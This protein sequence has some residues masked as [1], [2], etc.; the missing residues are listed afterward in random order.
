[1][2]YEW[3]IAR[4]PLQD[5]QKYFLRRYYPYQVKGSRYRRISADRPSRR[6][7]SAPLIFRAASRV[8][9]SLLDRA[10]IILR[11]LRFVKGVLKIF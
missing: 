9:T 6:S 8:F 7:G 11:I 1:M 2:E 5:I 4:S 10:P 3:R